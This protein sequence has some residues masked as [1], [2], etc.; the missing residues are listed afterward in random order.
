MHTYFFAILGSN[1]HGPVCVVGATIH[2]GYRSP[3]SRN[4]VLPCPP[5]AVWASPPPSVT[6]AR[7]RRLRSADTRTLLVTNFGDR[8]YSAAEPR[9]W[10]YLPTELRQPELSYSRFRHS[11]KSFL[12]GRWYKSAVWLPLSV[13]AHQKYSNLFTYIL[14]YLFI[15][16]HRGRA[17]KRTR[18]QR[19]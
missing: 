7:P 13:T 11:L 12:F 4:P 3:Q 15:L 17:E 8:A 10:N 16:L 14:T 6:D 5:G 19:D 18:R 1:F 2:F 9:V